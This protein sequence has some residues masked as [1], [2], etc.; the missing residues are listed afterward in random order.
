MIKQVNFDKL[1]AKLGYTI[2]PII[3]KPK[4]C[5]YFEKKQYI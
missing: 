1:T 2:T 3:I 5:V 4:I